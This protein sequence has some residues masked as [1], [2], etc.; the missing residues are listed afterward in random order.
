MNPGRNDPCPC[1]SGKKYK[2]CCLAAELRR[3]ESP[4]ALAWKR[5]R[6]AIEGLPER[7]GRFV[8]DVYGPNAIEEA[9]AEFMVWEGG[10]FDPE[11]P[12]T[13][14]FMPWL[15]HSWKPDPWEDEYAID[16]SLRGRTPTSVFLERHARQLDPL[17]QRYLEAC[18]A[19]PFSFY[20]IL[21]CD[22][23]RGF[24]TRDVLIG[25]EHEVLERLATES[26]E[27][28]DIL[29]AQLVPIDGIVLLEA[30]S[31][32]VLPPADKIAAI[33]LREEIEQAPPMER[34]STDLLRD[35]AY[36]IRE[37]FLELVEP[38]LERRP[39]VLHNTDGELM[40]LQRVIFDFDD[41]ERALG[42]F[43]RLPGISDVDVERAPD[44]RLERAELSWTKTGNREHASWE[45]TM[46]GNVEIT[47]GRIV[48]LV[49]SD[50]RA[51]AFRDFVQ[52][53]LGPAARYRDTEV[54]ERDEL[55]AELDPELPAAL[56]SMDA[57][58][59]S[60]EIVE[61]VVPEDFA[62]NPEVRAHLAR[63]FEQHY[64]DW[65]TQEVPALGDRRPIDVVQEPSGREKVEALVVGIERDAARV[66]PDVGAAVVARL[67]QRLGLTS[68]DYL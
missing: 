23:G 64:D 37:V 27:R 56:Q 3:S 11:S 22:P 42:A 10:A 59:E 20:E 57:E 34:D 32:Y 41:V 39:P 54:V 35:W 29:F 62:D 45:S 55:D 66:N 65:A 16:A 12:I 51:R 49:N 15:Y 50:E 68:N 60:S 25:E 40:K 2:H 14:L 36:E 61:E 7:L 21:R 18:L 43:T 9:W 13:A 19:A 48:A 26:M 58:L 4:E 44:G 5:V 24:R 53:S 33:E 17:A 38:Y 8:A 30:C 31:P 47:A 63:M 6:R 1:G 28:G 46:L 52:R 67:R